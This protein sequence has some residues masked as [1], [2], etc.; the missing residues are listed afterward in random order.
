MTTFEKYE[1]AYRSSSRGHVFC[2]PVNNA[3]L[4]SVKGC[5]VKLNL[6]RN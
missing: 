5:Y 4:S 6:N 3:T 2:D 1:L